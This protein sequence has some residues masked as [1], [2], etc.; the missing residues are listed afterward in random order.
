MIDENLIEKILVQFI[1]KLPS[2]YKNRF[3]G[4]A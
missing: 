1:E 4:T 2:T 3:L